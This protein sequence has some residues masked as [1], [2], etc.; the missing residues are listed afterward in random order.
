MALGIGSPCGR[1]APSQLGSCRGES[2]PLGARAQ[3]QTGPLAGGG[4]ARGSQLHCD[5]G[6]W[7]C[8]FPVALR[9]PR[10]LQLLY[11]WNES[12]GLT[13]GR[14]Q[15][16]PPLEASGEFMSSLLQW[17]EAPLPLSKARGAASD[18][19]SASASSAVVTS[20]SACLIKDTSD[21]SH[22]PLPGNAGHSPLNPLLHLPSPL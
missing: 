9:V 4:L 11:V 19:D 15:G 8:W 21:C 10:L 3:P 5:M 17:L 14:W 13:P 7:V 22:F 18:S 1:T 16:R 20:P 12:H 2:V 6:T